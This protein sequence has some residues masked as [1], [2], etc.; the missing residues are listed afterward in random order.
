[1]NECLDGLGLKYKDEAESSV[2]VQ[3]LLYLILD[4]RKLLNG[5]KQ[6]NE[7]IRCMF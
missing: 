2:Q 4:I 1:M 7:M 6:R 3:E 5:L